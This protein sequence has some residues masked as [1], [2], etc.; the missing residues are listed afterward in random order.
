MSTI[1]TLCIT[2]ISQFPEVTS[3]LERLG[4]VTY[5]PNVTHDEVCD[6]LSN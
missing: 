4:E 2:S 6:Y 1:K 3:I 5:V